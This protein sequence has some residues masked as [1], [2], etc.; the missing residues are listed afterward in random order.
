MLTIGV[1]LISYS[2]ALLT[3]PVSDNFC[4]LF[5]PQALESSRMQSDWFMYMLI[6]YIEV[7]NIEYY[8][9]VSILEQETGTAPKFFLDRTTSL[10]VIQRFCLKQWRVN[11]AGCFCESTQFLVM[12]SD[13]KHQIV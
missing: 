8:V 2:A 3:A 9:S 11:V 7:A 1:M 6:L 10:N 5:C 12:F 13:G 4:T